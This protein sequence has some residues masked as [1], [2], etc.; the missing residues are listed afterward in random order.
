MSK[1]IEIKNAVVEFLQENI[2]CHDITVV[3]LEKVGDNWEAIVEVYEDDSFLKAMNLPPKNVR[4][5]YSVKL[6]DQKEILAFERTA[7]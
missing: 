2:K 6:D 1:I 5:F 3:K 4:L 7:E